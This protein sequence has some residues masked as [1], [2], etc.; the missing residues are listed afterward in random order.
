MFY[1][2]LWKVLSVYYIAL[3]DVDFMCQIGLF[4]KLTYK[5]YENEVLEYFS[6]CFREAGLYNELFDWKNYTI[7]K[8]YLSQILHFGSSRQIAVYLGYVSTSKALPVNNHA[9]E[10]S[11]PNINDGEDG[12]DE[13]DREDDGYLADDE[14]N[15]VV[16]YQNSVILERD[17]DNLFVPFNRHEE[18]Q[19]RHVSLEGENSDQNLV[20]DNYQPT[21]IT[22]VVPHNLDIDD[23]FNENHNIVSIGEDP[24]NINITELYVGENENALID[25]N[26]SVILDGRFHPDIDYISEGEHPNIEIVVGVH[27]DLHQVDVEDLENNLVI[28][29][30]RDVQSIN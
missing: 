13:E 27:I 9:A 21:C 4:T 19:H 30:N 29:E 11:D 23:I 20:A 6:S 25:E 3:K 7:S 15:T 5:Q 16:D 14:D 26:V 12:D 17:T 28:N 22:H 18:L 1:V 10:E 8:K 2:H 24:S